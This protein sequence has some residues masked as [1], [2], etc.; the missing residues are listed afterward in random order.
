MRHTANAGHAVLL[1]QRAGMVLAVAG[2][3]G[4]MTVAA[5]QQ[6]LAEKTGVPLNMQQVLFG[7]PQKVLPLPNDK[8]SATLASLGVPSGET[9]VVRA[10]E[11]SAEA[12]AAQTPPTSN[13]LLQPAQGLL[14]PPNLAPHQVWRL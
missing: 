11:G 7:Y 2:L 12:H 8:H 4:A 9:L 5:F 14:A 13:G 3:S 6:L 1:M 10:K